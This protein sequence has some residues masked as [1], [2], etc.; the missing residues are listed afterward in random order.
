MFCPFLTVSRP[1]AD[2]CIGVGHIVCVTI[3]PHKR[4]TPRVSP[5]VFQGA[6]RGGA[7]D[8]GKTHGKTFGNPP[9]A[10]TRRSATSCRWPARAIAIRASPPAPPHESRPRVRFLLRADRDLQ[11]VAVGG[12]DSDVAAPAR[13]G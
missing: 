10:T 5:T 7:S 1:G 12:D 9:L 11:P 4:G 6:D 2:V 13:N 8:G 3:P